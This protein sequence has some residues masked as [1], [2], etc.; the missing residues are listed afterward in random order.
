MVKQ[1][2]WR[3]IQYLQK[4]VEKCKKVLRKKKAAIPSGAYLVVPLCSF[5]NHFVVFGLFRKVI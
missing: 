2:T 4:T 1:K 3:N 5:G